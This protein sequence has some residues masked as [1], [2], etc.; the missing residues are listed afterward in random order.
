M[1][2]ILQNNVSVSY[3]CEEERVYAKIGDANCVCVL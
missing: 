3:L 2:T 1:K